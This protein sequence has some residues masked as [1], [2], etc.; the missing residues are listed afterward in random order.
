MVAAS[1][2]HLQ[3]SIHNAPN[4]HFIHLINLKDPDVHQGNQLLFVHTF[5]ILFQLR[6]NDLFSEYVLS[7]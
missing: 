7:Y 1:S 3:L 2:L 5:Y 4:K 6:P